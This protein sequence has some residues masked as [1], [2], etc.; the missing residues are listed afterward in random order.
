MYCLMLVLG[1]MF[2]FGGIIW[3]GDTIEAFEKWLDKVN[4]K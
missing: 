3:I 1:V 4:G 2:F